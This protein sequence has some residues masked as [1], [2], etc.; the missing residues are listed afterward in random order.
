MPHAGG[1]RSGE[2]SNLSNRSVLFHRRST[3]AAT[4]SYIPCQNCTGALRSRCLWGR[5][6]R[7]KGMW[8]VEGR[9]GIEPAISRC[10]CG[11]ACQSTSCPKSAP[12]RDEP[13]RS[14]CRFLFQISL[15]SCHY[16]CFHIFLFG[17]NIGEDFQPRIQK[18]GSVKITQRIIH[19]ETSCSWNLNHLGFRWFLSSGGYSPS[20]HRTGS[21]RVLYSC[22]RSPPGHRAVCP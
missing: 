15:R 18:C 4:G 2:D 21:H 17:H 13:E 10:A 12:A 7:R 1:W 22:E 5:L 3:V 19:S 14:L 8:Q 9:A 6:I 11:C 16:T 20:P